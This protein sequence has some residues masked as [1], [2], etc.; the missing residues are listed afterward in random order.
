MKFNTGSAT[1]FELKVGN[2]YPAQ[3]KQT[4]TFWVVVGI[5]E[6]GV[7]LLRIDSD[8]NVVG[9]QTYGKHVF[10]GSNHHWNRCERLLG[11]VK[12][13][14]NFELHIEWRNG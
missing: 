13:I 4:G 11:H 9:A 3:G 12:N 1:N 7:A 2:V 10:D 14:E 6:T 5:M 8:G